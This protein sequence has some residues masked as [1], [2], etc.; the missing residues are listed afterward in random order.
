MNENQDLKLQLQNLLHRGYFLLSLIFFATCLGL[1]AFGI[2]PQVNDIFANQD[3]IEQEQQN[4]NNLNNKLKQVAEITSDSAFASIGIVDDILYTKN[5]FFESLYTISQLADDQNVSIPRLE[6]SPGLI[7][8]PSAQFRAQQSARSAAARNASKKASEE[9]PVFLEVRGQYNSLV[10]FLHNLENYTPFVSVVYS[11][12]QNSL[13]GSAVG[14]FEVLIQYYPPDVTAKL[15][16]ALPS[17]SVEDQDTIN[18]LRAFDF[19]D[20]SSVNLP[21]FVN[22]N[23]D[24]PFMGK[25]EVTEEMIE[26]VI[27]QQEETDLQE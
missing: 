6:L 3:K 8:T 27:N 2:V 13:S 10:N 21:D 18:L 9:V 1:A 11:E 19:Y 5:P 4:L 17:L 15:E 14:Q 16:E 24:N 25:I 23:R 20:L 12:I 26:E 7:A 22:Y